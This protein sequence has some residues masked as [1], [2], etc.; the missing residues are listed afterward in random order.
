MG[1]HVMSICRYYP[2]VFCYLV[3]SFCIFKIFLTGFAFPI[4]TVSGCCTGLCYC[5]MGIHIMAICRYYPAACLYLVL[6]IRVRKT[7]TTVFTNI[8]C[9]I[10]CFC[11][12]CFYF[13]NFLK[14]MLSYFFE[15]NI[16]KLIGKYL[17][18]CFLSSDNIFQTGTTCK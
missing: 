17:S 18:C 16:L 6:S 10:S 3:F 13:F 5:C 12:G 4:C 8:I 9:S 15:T 14:R 1:I 7:L 11:T 2:A